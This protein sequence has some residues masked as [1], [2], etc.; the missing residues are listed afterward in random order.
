[1]E[2]LVAEETITIHKQNYVRVIYILDGFGCFE[3]WEWVQICDVV[4]GLA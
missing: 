2:F 1:M 3:N 4:G